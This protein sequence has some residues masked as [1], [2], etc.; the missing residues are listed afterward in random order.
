MSMGIDRRRFLQLAAAGLVLNVIALAPHARAWS[1]PE[2]PVGPWRALTLASLNLLQGNQETALVL[3][4][5][6]GEK[7]AQESAGGGFHFRVAP[8]NVRRLL[9]P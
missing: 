5:S 8:V 4:G 6:E 9:P 7:F 1:E 2:R 3:L